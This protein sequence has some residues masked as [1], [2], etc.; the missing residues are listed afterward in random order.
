MPFFAPLLTPSLTSLERM[1]KDTPI[2]ISEGV[3]VVIAPRPNEKDGQLW[4]VFL[5]NHNTF[6]LNNVL[7]SSRGYGSVDG[8]DKVTATLRH[9]IEEIPAQSYHLIE[10]IQID[11]F[12][13]NNE[14]WLSYN[15]N[16]EMLEKKFIFQPNTIQLEALTKIE[17]LDREAVRC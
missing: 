6:S 16:Q 17:T 9:F 7:I 8:R 14:Y 12:S 15:H 3:E 2:L 10:P 5:V 11:V 4:D 1:K 13:I